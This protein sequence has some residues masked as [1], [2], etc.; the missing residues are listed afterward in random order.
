[1][2]SLYLEIECENCGA[3]IKR[4]KMLRPIKEILNNLSNRCPSCGKL[5]SSSDFSVDAKPI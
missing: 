2:I 4:M 5:L 1:M 3:I